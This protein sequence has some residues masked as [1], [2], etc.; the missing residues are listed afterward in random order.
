MT[1]PGEGMPTGHRM[2]PCGRGQADN[3]GRPEDDRG[4]CH[5]PRYDARPLRGPCGRPAECRCGQADWP[6][7]SVVTGKELACPARQCLGRNA[8]VGPHGSRT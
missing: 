1:V 8:T 6:D 2:G 7:M 5:R 4:R 3:T